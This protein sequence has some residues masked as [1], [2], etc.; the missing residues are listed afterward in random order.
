MFRRKGGARCIEIGRQIQ[1]YLDDGLDPATAAKVS[2]HL[3]A[4]RR[5]GLTADDYRRLKLALAET[6]A[7]MS[8]RTPATATS[9][10]RRPRLR[11]HLTGVTVAEPFA[12]ALEAAR[13]NHPADARRH[14]R[15]RARQSCH[16]RRGRRRR[17][18]QGS[19][20]P[21]HRPR[22]AVPAPVRH[23][24]QRRD[25]ARTHLLDARP[26]SAPDSTNRHRSPAT[27]DC[28]TGRS[29]SSPDAPNSCS[30]SASTST[31][32]RRPRSP[33]ARSSCCADTSTSSTPRSRRCS[34][35]DSATAPAG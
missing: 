32:T 11:Q 24:R 35:N 30:D 9:A 1:T 29:T 10:R 25:P 5:C 8:S 18:R 6:S 7:P 28:S 21:A 26:A 34:T 12:F 23:Q 15:R 31:P 33:L 13:S 16:P 27:N 2:S 17:P 4:C 19:R 14:R 20:P 22:G 3:H